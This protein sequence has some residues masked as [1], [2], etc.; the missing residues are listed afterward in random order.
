MSKKNDQK[1]AL[2]RSFNSMIKAFEK[3][4]DK[5]LRNQVVN[6]LIAEIKKT[7]TELKSRSIPDDQ[8][9]GAL[10]DEV[11]SSVT[12]SPAVIDEMRASIMAS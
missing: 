10:N 6:H 8:A 1:K 2:K 7:T 12:P 9:A 4:R 5:R 3:Q 11:D